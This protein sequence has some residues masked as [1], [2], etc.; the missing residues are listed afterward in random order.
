M[1]RILSTIVPDSS[2]QLIPLSARLQQKAY[3]TKTWKDLASHTLH[4]ER[5]AK[6]ERQGGGP[7]NLSG[8]A[9]ADKLNFVT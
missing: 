4:S 6:L 1:R 8:Q 3:M 7:I 2:D 9:N 5:I